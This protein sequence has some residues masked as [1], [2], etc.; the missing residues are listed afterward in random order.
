MFEFLNRLGKFVTSHLE[1]SRLASVSN[2]SWLQICVEIKRIG[3]TETTRICK[4][5]VTVKTQTTQH[6]QNKA[7]DLHPTRLSLDADAKLVIFA[8]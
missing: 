7:S 3:D 4:G 2:Q 5:T 8:S 1:Q 6:I